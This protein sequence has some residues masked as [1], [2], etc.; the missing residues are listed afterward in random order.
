M[1]DKIE[2]IADFVYIKNDR[3]GDIMDNEL[4]DN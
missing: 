4:K 3:I 2:H 1:C